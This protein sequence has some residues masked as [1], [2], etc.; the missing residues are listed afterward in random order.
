MNSGYTIFLQ[1]TIGTILVFAAVAKIFHRYSLRPFLL[2]IGLSRRTSGMVSG[3]APVL[4]GLVGVALLSGIALPAAA[5]AAV[6]ALVFCVS[7]IFAKRIGVDEG[8]RCFG[9]LD[10]DKLSALPLVRAGVLAAGT[11]V[12]GSIYLKGGNA[13]M[14]SGLW[15]GSATVLTI[16]GIFAGIGYVVAFALLEQVHFFEQRRPRRVPT[17]KDEVS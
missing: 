17:P 8:C 11:L 2:A 14:W 7:L 12:L 6:L 5:A 13:A 1:A 15:K 4:E 9:F 16:L 3:T 10:P